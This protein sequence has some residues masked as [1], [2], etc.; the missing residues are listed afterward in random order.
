MFYSPRL[1][2]KKN[3]AQATRTLIPCDN[4]AMSMALAVCTGRAGRGAQAAQ[5]YLTRPCLGGPV[6]GQSTCVMRT[7]PQI[8]FRCLLKATLENPSA[9]P[10]GGCWGGLSSRA[11]RWG[12]FSDLLLP[13]V[14]RI[15][16][17]PKPGCLVGSSVFCLFLKH[18]SQAVL[19]HL[20]KSSS[21]FCHLV[22][23]C[24]RATS[25]WKSGSTFQG[26]TVIR[27]WLLVRSTYSR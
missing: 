23:A 14:K 8:L 17:P 16:Q 27:V 10:S 9:H 5:I 24:I 22:F 2:L 7:L 20:T 3:R 19:F 26:N 1:R 21:L 15:T 25:V 4:S 11:D 6:G 13:K 18:P 12:R